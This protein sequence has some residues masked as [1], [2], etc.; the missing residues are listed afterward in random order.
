MLVAGLYSVWQHLNTTSKA[1]LGG[2]SQE[3]NKIENHDAEWKIFMSS[4]Y[5]KI[6][7]QFAGSLPWD[8]GDYVHLKSNPV[9]PYL[10]NKIFGDWF[11][12][13]FGGVFL[14][15]WNDTRNISC[16]LIFIDFDGF[17]ATELKSCLPTK[18]WESE[19]LSTG[20]VKFTFLT[21]DAEVV[22]LVEQIDRKVNISNP[23]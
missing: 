23:L 17:S 21:S 6:D 10:D 7:Q 12:I 15:K 13:D 9:I 8:S 19:K 14:Q 4:K 20:E 18:D 22:Y 11:L 3:P 2:E 16:D 5:I 1:V